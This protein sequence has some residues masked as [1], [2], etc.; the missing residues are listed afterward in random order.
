MT[1]YTEGKVQQ[2]RYELHTE[3]RAAK[4]EAREREEWKGGKEGEEDGEA[5]ERAGE[6]RYREGPVACP[7]WAS[8]AMYIVLPEVDA[9]N[10]YR[11]VSKKVPYVHFAAST[12]CL[13]CCNLQHEMHIG[14]DCSHDQTV[15]VLS[16]SACKWPRLVTR[17]GQGASTG[18][19]TLPRV[20]LIVTRITSRHLTSASQSQLQSSILS[21][22][23]WQ[24]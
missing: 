8:S 14:C 21:Q 2:G 9:A 16:C 6:G 15:P 7:P 22:S 20:L 1:R 12:G 18:T 19:S 24:P 4:E 11:K 17:R 10:G 13:G 3:E 5:V 23:Y